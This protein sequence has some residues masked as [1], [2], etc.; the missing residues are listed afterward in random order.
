MM[1]MSAV[2]GKGEWDITVQATDINTAF[3]EKARQGIYGKWAL[4]ECSSFMRQRYFRAAGEGRWEVTAEV[5]KM[6]SFSCHNLVQDSFPQFMDII[7][8]KNV[9]MYFTETAAYRC[10]KGSERAWSTAVGCW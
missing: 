4:R 1:L 3:L 5:R 6:V 7:V 10:C 2:Q 9:L 8:C